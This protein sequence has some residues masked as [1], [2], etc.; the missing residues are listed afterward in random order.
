MMHSANLIGS[1][2][3]GVA[4]VTVILK[5]CVPAKN[6]THQVSASNR[7]TPNS[8]ILPSVIGSPGGCFIP[9]GYWK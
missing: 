7:C 8:R 5:H 3:A 2:V 6:V 1:I 9:A 4:L